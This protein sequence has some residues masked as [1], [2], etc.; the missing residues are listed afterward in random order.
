MLFMGNSIYYYDTIDQFDKF[1]SKQDRS[2]ID[3]HSAIQWMYLLQQQ[4]RY[5]LVIYH[6]RAWDNP[7]PI[8]TRIIIHLH[9]LEQIKYLTNRKLIPV[10]NQDISINMATSQ[11][12]IFRHKYLKFLKPKFGVKLDKS[13][14]RSK[15]DKFIQFNG[16]IFFDYSRGRINLV[17]V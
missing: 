1:Y 12:K 11:L 4:N 14:S 2:D 15:I 16:Y 10:H 3:C 13:R 9:N 8:P 7:R 17:N 6:K 5:S